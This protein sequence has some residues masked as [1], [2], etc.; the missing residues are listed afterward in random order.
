MNRKSNTYRHAEA[1]LEILSLSSPDPN[2][3]PIVEPFKE[4]ILALCEKFGRSGQSGGSAP[5]TA[6]VLVNAIKKLLLQEPISQITG[7]DE[8]WICVSDKFGEECYQ[9][10][11]CSAIFKDGLGRAYYL[12][13]IVK[14]TQTGITW[15]GPFYPS[16][17]DYELRRGKLGC[18]HYIKSFPFTP[19]T[20]Y[21][22]VIEVEVE[23]DNWE[24]YAKDPKQLEKVW[25]YYDKM[26]MNRKAYE[27]PEG[28]AEQRDSHPD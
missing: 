15:S 28:E 24:M 5:I 11:R 21:I 7:I 18:K 25:K 27:A 3:R 1:E 10:I 9:N 8:E 20:F 16:K 22:D 17:E 4:E 13:A 2:N 14:K 19:K 23:K 12:D 26:E 6:A